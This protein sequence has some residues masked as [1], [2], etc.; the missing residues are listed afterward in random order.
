M[1]PWPV[2]F[3]APR[4]SRWLGP[5]WLDH[6]A[7]AV[8]EPDAQ[9]DRRERRREHDGGADEQGV[10]VTPVDQR[11]HDERAEDLP[12]A[13]P[14]RQERDVDNPAT[15]YADTVPS[16]TSLFGPVLPCSGPRGTARIGA[17]GVYAALGQLIADVTGTDYAAAATRLVL[18]PL[19]MNASRFP[20]SWPHDDPDAVT[21]YELE[22][23]GIFLPDLDEVAAVPAAA[24]LWTTAADLVRFGA[25]WSSLLPG[26]LAS[27]AVRP[28]ASAADGP[29]QSGLGWRLNTAYGFA[30]EIGNGPGGSASLMVRL[31]DGR[32]YVAL[33]NRKVSVSPLN[34]RVFR[35][36]A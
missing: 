24:G 9:R 15:P 11:L 3:T 2:A 19:G 27:E 13:V 33:A 16:L 1:L 36:G 21:G 23:D 28:H 26:N 32:P 29:G 34:I 7:D 25:G 4:G 31:S 20:V 35:L 22:P 6:S 12:D 17:H 18:G 14:G 30:S 8:R 10:A 5:R